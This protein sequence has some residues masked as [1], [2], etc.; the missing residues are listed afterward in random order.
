MRPKREAPRLVADEVGMVIGDAEVVNQLDLPRRQQIDDR[1]PVAVRVEQL[2]ADGEIPGCDPYPA[3]SARCFNSATA[4]Q[5]WNQPT[6][7]SLFS[8]A[9]RARLRATPFTRFKNSLPTDLFL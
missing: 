4:I 9:L 8:W 5:P 6:L 3:L 2:V 7:N 1:Q